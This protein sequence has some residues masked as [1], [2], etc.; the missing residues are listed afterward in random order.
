MKEIKVL[1]G[2]RLFDGTGG[3]VIENSVVVIKNDRF[4][5]VGGADGVEIPKGPNVE[6]IDTTGMT[7]LPGLIESHKH[8]LDKRP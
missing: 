7:V 2:G 3:E 4:C 8:L 1:K 5:A 6:I